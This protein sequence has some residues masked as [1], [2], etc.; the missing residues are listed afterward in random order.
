MARLGH[1][2]VGLRPP[3]P[4]LLAALLEHHARRHVGAQRS[5]G[6]LLELRRAP[7]SLPLDR[8]ARGQ[9]LRTACRAMGRV[10][11]RVQEHEGRGRPPSRARCGARRARPAPPSRSGSMIVRTLP[12]EFPA[13]VGAITS[14]FSASLRITRPVERCADASSSRGW[15]PGEP[16]RPP[17]RPR[18]PCRSAATDSACS[19]AR[20]STSRR[21]PRPD[22]SARMTWPRPRLDGRLGHISACSRLSAVSK[23]ELRRPCAR[24]SGSASHSEPSIDEL[25]LVQP[26]VALDL[27]EGLVREFSR[28]GLDDLVPLRSP[29]P[30]A[31]Q[32]AMRGQQSRAATASF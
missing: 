1:R 10:G 6:D 20:G 30:R 5:R 28:A 19:G 2:H 17:R 31:L 29:R 26:A 32:P 3:R 11:I 4:G 13:P 8:S 9:I 23:A 14:P 7:R 18:S 16:R 27:A 24:S 21:R 22:F 15:M 12:R 25:V